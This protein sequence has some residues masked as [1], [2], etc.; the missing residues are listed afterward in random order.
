MDAKDFIVSFSLEFSSCNA[1]FQDGQ[2]IS[3][4][5][6]IL[7]KALNILDTKNSSEEVIIETPIRD[8]NGNRLGHMYFS[9]EED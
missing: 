8:S 5:K 6:A 3:E 2:A 1:A 7:Q 4:T 9:I